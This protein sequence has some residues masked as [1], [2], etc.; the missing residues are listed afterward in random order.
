MKISNTTGIIQDKFGMVKATRMLAEAGFDCVD[1]SLINIKE[2]IYTGEG[3]NIIKEMKTVADAFGVSFNQ[4]HAPFHRQRD[5]YDRDMRPLMPRAF[6][7]CASLGIPH[8][9]VHPFKDYKR[10]Y[11][12]ISEEYDKINLDFYESLTPLANE[13]GVKIAIENMF[14]RHPQD[15]T[16]IIDGTFSCPYHHI[17][18]YNRLSDKENFTL[19]IDVGHTALTDRDPADS[20]RVIGKERLGGLHIHDVDLREDLHTLPGLGKINFESISRA[21]GEID[22]DGEYTLESLNFLI[23]FEDD[24]LPEALAFSARR[25]AYYADMAEKYRKA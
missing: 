23:G 8:L 12:G 9:V 5:V 6:E 15:L 2:P 14:C 1:L 24:F 3:A 7:I 11:K 10:L 16:K 13:Y 18:F 19:L 17:E 21:L 4:A 20:I 22:Y 25:A